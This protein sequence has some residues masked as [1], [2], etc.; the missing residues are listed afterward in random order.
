MVVPDFLS[1]SV[2]VTAKSSFN[3]FI[4]ICAPTFLFLSPL[5]ITWLI[6][7]IIQF[8]CKRRKS[9]WM[10]FRFPSFFPLIQHTQMHLAT[11][12]MTRH[13]VL[14]CH[15]LYTT[16]SVCLSKEQQFWLCHC[17]FLVL[18]KREHLQTTETFLQYLETNKDQRRYFRMQEEHLVSVWKHAV[19]PS[20]CDL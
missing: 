3:A 16:R 4:L 10:T 14:V 2:C 5:S 6:D 12:T 20:C 13:P 11:L 15:P 19:L 1:K 7:A 17:F 8:R 18:A 9:K